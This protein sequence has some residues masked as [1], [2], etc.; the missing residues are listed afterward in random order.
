[1]NAVRY[2]E[3][4]FLGQ[5]IVKSKVLLCRNYIK[6]YCAGITL[7][8]AVRALHQVLLCTVGFRETIACCTVRAQLPAATEYQLWCVT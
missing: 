1:M 7:G 6:S 3:S 8:P 4:L 2:C 5:L